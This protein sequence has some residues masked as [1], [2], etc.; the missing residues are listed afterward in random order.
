M[1]APFK[2]AMVVSHRLSTVTTALSLKPLGKQFAI[3]CLRRS[4]KQGEDHVGAKFGDEGVPRDTGLS[5]AKETLL[6][7]SAV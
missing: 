1:M 4:N 6:I 5:Y 2:T 3:E 7:S